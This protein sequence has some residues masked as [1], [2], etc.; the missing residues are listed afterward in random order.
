MVSIPARR[1]GGADV[2][3]AEVTKNRGTSGEES[4]FWA[5]ARTQTQNLTTPEGHRTEL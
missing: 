5:E 1:R 3:Q 2:T 4:S